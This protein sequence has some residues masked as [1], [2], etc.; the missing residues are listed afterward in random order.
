MLSHDCIEVDAYFSAAKTLFITC[1]DAA[2]EICVPEGRVG[3]DAFVCQNLANEV[4]SYREE[5]AFSA[6]IE[7][8]VSRESIQRIVVCGHTDCTILASVLQWDTQGALPEW[9]RHTEPAARFVQHHYSDAAQ[10][11]ALKALATENVRYQL[12]NLRA[13]PAVASA[14]AREQLSVHGWV[15]DQSSGEMLVL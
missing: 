3:I 14:I 8:F 10:P 15:Y 4:P 2:L 11:N 7:Y 1:S 9:F 13:H 6:T 12:A 5:N